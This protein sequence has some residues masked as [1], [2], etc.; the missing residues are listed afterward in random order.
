MQFPHLPGG[1]SGLTGW[2]RSRGQRATRAGSRS[3][4]A[5]SGAAPDLTAGVPRSRVLPP[6]P[7]RSRGLQRRPRGSPGNLAQPVGRRAGDLHEQGAHPER[8]RRRC[9][10]AAARPRA[11]GTAIHRA[12]GNR[13]AGGSGWHGPGSL[14]EVFHRQSQ[15]R[16][17]R[18]P[19]PGRLLRRVPRGEE[20]GCAS[21]ARGARAPQGRGVASRDRGGVAGAGG[22]RSRRAC[23]RL[24]P[25]PG[26]TIPRSICLD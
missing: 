25:A 17:P 6:L 23:Y 9:P 1:H 11:A 8:H 22:R 19:T 3:W 7:F 13:A 5:G 10:D 20:H 24:S 18:P 4:R 16:A 2:G 26:F 14:P 15:H 21:H 12:Y